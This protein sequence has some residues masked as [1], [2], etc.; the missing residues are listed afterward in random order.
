MLKNIPGFPDYGITK[1]G[2]VWS[3]PH[4]TPHGHKR[5]GRWLKPRNDS[6]GY[7]LVTLRN[8][9]KVFTGRIHRLVLETFVGPCPAGEESRH[10]DG[11]KQNN[12]LDNLC[13]GTHQENMTDKL[14]HGSVPCGIQHSLAKLTEQN[15]RMII[16]MYRTG[17]FTMREIALQ[18]GI[19]AP[20]VNNILKRK[21]WKH[22][23]S[24]SAALR[25]NQK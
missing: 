24:S 9:S 4:T 19:T 23:W 5:K 21:T 3:K 14:V 20:L 18:Y 13:W 25:R 15:V 7:R 6:G 8:K 1:D 22:L 17:L 2:E 16:Y 11:N 12:R 10:L